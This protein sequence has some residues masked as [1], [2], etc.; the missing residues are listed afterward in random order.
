MSTSRIPQY[1]DHSFDGML[2]WFA[3]MS[4]RGLLFHPDDPADEIYEIATGNRTFSSDESGQIN[5]IISTMFE[6]HGDQGYEAAYPIFMK[7]LCI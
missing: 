7:R 1:F 5:K 2:I 4:E 6:L 3:S